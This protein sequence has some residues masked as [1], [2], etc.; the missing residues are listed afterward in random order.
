MKELIQDQESGQGLVEYG[1]III[2]VAILII[3]VL[4]VLGQSI[5]DMYSSVVNQL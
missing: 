1:M 5:G 2:L 4:V 3:A